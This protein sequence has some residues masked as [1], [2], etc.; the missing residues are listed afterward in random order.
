[1]N[2]AVVL[3]RGGMEKSLRVETNGH[4]HVYTD[5]LVSVA[6]SG[7]RRSLYPPL[8]YQ[9]PYKNIQSSVFCVH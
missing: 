7:R 9:C 2:S 6:S 1:M 3:R 5:E 8:R 4:L